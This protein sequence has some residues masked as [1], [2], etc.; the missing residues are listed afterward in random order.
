MLQRLIDFFK[1]T[2]KY[3]IAAYTK[4]SFICSKILNPFFQVYFFYLVTG[5]SYGF[6]SNSKY[7]I[8]NV[9]LLVCSSVFINV[10][11]TLVRE[12]VFGTLQYLEV[13]RINNMLILFGKSLYFL[14]DGLIS[15]FVGLGII[16]I[17]FR[18]EF[19]FDILLPY[20]ILVVCVML[21]SCTFGLLLGSFGLVLKDINFL[22]NSVIYLITLICGAN[23]SIQSLPMLLRWLAHILPITNGIQSSKLLIESDKGWGCYLVVE[24]IIMVIY[25]LLATFLF[26]KLRKKA[27]IE[28]KLDLY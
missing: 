26:S 8:A 2:Y 10:G 9:I 17:L 15:F 12:R 3:E 24:L 7:V 6:D 5:M 18:I 11:I 19:P 16:T 14:F 4:K 13:S 23:F 1:L 22:F 20:F 25:Y 28:A 27:V 21:S